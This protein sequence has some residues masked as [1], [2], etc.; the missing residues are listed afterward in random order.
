VGVQL[1]PRLLAQA[2]VIAKGN[3][4]RDVQRLV[5]QYGGQAS[6]WVKKS[7]PSI[8]IA[9]DLIEYHWYEHPR[10]GRFEL[11]RRQV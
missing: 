2:R 1:S 8:E 11:K 7:S 5:T 6:R 3:R 9:G 4:I 10:L